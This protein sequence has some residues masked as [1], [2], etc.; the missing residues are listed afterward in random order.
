M[1]VFQKIKLLFTLNKPAGELVDELKGAKSNW[2]TV[3]FWATLLAT[4][5]TL[6]AGL[7]G[8]VSPEVSLIAGSAIAALYNIVNGLQDADKPTTSGLF[9]STKFW[10]GAL[11]QVQ[12][13][14]LAIKTGGVDPKV[15]EIAMTSLGF[16]MTLAQNIA[17]QEPTTPQ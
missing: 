4:L 17:S 15:L 16:I 3:K 14:L 9:T 8:V 5:G 1:S 12:S 13:A 7:T 11:A 10:L 2:K 6:A